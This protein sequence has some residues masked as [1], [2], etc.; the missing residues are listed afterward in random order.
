MSAVWVAFLFG[1]VAGA[2]V[3]TVM[4]GLCKASGE[5]DDAARECAWV[6]CR[7]HHG[8]GINEKPTTPRP[9]VTPGRQ[10]P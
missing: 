2:A 8:I 1:M 4:L 5:A 9:D 10:K 6:P 7:R 3:M